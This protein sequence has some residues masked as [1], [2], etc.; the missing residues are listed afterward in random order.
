[1]GWRESLPNCRGKLIRPVIASAER[2][3]SKIRLD[4]SLGSSQPLASD[5]GRL[6]P[7]PHFHNPRRLRQLGLR[8]RRRPGIG[9]MQRWRHSLPTR[10]FQPSTRLTDSPPSCR[11][12]PLPPRICDPYESQTAYTTVR[13]LRHLL[14]PI[15]APAD[16]LSQQGE[17]DT[18][19]VSHLGEG[20]EGRLGRTVEAGRMCAEC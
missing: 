18:R 7:L 14:D 8:F 4:N 15:C 20:A 2:V 10:S 9:E 3:G 6:A 16:R 11:P 12:V 17:H 5:I 13:G 19:L 1:M